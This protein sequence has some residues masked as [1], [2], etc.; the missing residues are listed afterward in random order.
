MTN[1]KHDFQEV[2]PNVF[3]CV[4]CGVS[5]DYAEGFK[6]GEESKSKTLDDYNSNKEFNK[7]TRAERDICLWNEGI[8]QERLRLKVEVEKIILMWNADAIA[9]YN[10]VFKGRK[11]RR[12]WHI[13][14]IESVT[15]SIRT[16]L[17]ALFG[18]DK[19]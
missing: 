14:A 10:K 6:A 9:F 12:Q 8:K 7:L 5:D 18:D 16:E 11:E 1:C 15:D 13:D 3:L 4:S 2:D 17:S 19:K